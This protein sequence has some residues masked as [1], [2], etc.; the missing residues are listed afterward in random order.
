M[1]PALQQRQALADS[2]AR[3]LTTLGLKRVAREL[4]LDD[5]LSKRYGDQ[6]MDNGADAEQQGVNASDATGEGK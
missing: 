2:L 6:N 1:I 5:Y 4:S 3:C